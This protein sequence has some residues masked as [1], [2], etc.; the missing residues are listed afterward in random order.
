MT[1]VTAKIRKM[2][3]RDIAFPIVNTI[4]L[5]LLMF[6][7]LYPVLNTV[8]YSFNSGLDAV[9]GGIGLWPRKFSTEA[10]TELLQ[11]PAVYKAFWISLSKTVICAFPA[12]V[13]AAQ[14][15]HHGAGADHVYQRRP[16]P[17]LPADLTDA[18]TEEYLLGLYYSDDVQLL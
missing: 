11:D 16:D 5:I 15:H 2:K 10:Y 17:Q 6:I 4:I 18:G 1:V 12:G 14:V 3:K 8:A 13:C 7:T 9:K